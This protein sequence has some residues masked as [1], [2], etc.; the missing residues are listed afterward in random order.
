MHGN[1]N[2][3]MNVAEWCLKM[4]AWDKW[5]IYWKQINN[6][7]IGVPRF[8][9]WGIREDWISAEY[10]KN[11]P[12]EHWLELSS[13]ISCVVMLRCSWSSFAF[14]HHLA[15]WTSVRKFVGN[16]LFSSYYSY[17]KICC[18]FHR[19]CCLLLNKKWKFS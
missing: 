19:T 9:L 2:F 14:N 8:L 11:T 15:G 18:L 6:H 7:V 16:W 17:K 12:G 5:Y 3:H 10:S 13:W 1:L 4:L